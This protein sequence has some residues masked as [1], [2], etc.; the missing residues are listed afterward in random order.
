MCAVAVAVT[1]R[2]EHAVVAAA[3]A[4]AIAVAGLA[5]I[6]GSASTAGRLAAVCAVTGFTVAPAAGAVTAMVPPASPGRRS[7]APWRPPRPAPPR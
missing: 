2:G 6:A 4:D 5:V 3:I 1:D 7:A